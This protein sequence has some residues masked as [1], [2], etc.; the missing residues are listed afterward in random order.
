MKKLIIFFVIILISISLVSA[1][2]DFECFGEECP[3]FI[4]KVHME[5]EEFI[6]D[7][8]LHNDNSVSYSQTIGLKYQETTPFSTNKIIRYKIPLPQ[9][10]K[11]DTEIKVK[12]LFTGKEFERRYFNFENNCHGQFIFYRDRNSIVLCTKLQKQYKNYL[13]VLKVY[14]RTAIFLSFC[15][16]T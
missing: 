13:K 10:S 4:K 2:E 12:E 11:I 16:C 8:I 14:L 1:E 9:Q 6:I 7:T 5:I 15:I 3:E